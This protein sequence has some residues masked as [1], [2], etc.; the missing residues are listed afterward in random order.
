MI[1][2][3][4]DS[5]SVVDGDFYIPFTAKLDESYTG[6]EITLNLQF[7][8]QPC[9]D[10]ECKAPNILNT[11]LTLPIGENGQPQNDK[12]FAGIDFTAQTEQTEGQ[13]LSENVVSN[14]Y[15]Q[16][17]EIEALITEHG[18]WGYFLVL[19]LAF[20]TGLLLSFSPCTYPMIPITVSIFAGQSRSIGKGF[21][22]SLFYVLSMAV[23]Y[24]IMGL[25]VSLIGGVFGAWLANPIVVISM[26]VVFVIFALSMFGVYSLEVPMSLRNKLGSTKKKS[27]IVGVIILGAIAALVIS[28]CV[29][30]FVFGILTYIS[31]VGNPL[32]GFL[33]LFVFAIGLGTLYMIVGTFSSAI[34]SLPGAGE[35]MET[36]KKFFGFVLLM[37]AL[38]FLRTIIPTDILA[39]LSGLLLLSLA[40]FGGGLDRLS[41]DSSMFDRLKKFI[42]ILAFIV[43]IYLLLGSL[44]SQGFIHKPFSGFSTTAE[45]KQK[46]IDWQTDL[47]RG[48]ADAKASGKPVLIDTWATWCA[49]C[50]VLE[51]KTFNNPDVA[52]EAKRFQALKIQLEKS[53][54]PESKQFMKKFGIKSYSLPTTLLLDSNGNVK[55]I[56]QGV[57]EPE[58]MI[59][60]MK[61]IK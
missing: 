42:G 31:T 54:S 39:I 4:D 33:I 38:Y 17:S 28:P 30:P 45:S 18:F 19:G 2:F 26:S 8:Y 55:K 43:S 51:E 36:V 11:S 53:D 50:K 35:W 13:A 1:P 5:L 59:A 7:E 32:F 25:I 48:L 37:M 46:L 9:N 12:I 16:T 21:I 14:D 24:G 56:M 40:V 23:I 57:V 34:N 61:K 27:G 15:Q 22:L 6:S 20:V 47:E 3:F 29:G 10:K 44:V 60:E 52:L 58:D 49:N 41:K